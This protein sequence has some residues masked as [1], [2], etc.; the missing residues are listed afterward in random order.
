LEGADG[1]LGLFAAV[2]VDRKEFDLRQEAFVDPM[3]QPGLHGK[4]VVVV[5]GR[6]L[7]DSAFEFDVFPGFHSL[8]SLLLISR[9]KVVDWVRDFAF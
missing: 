3:I 6:V 1:Y 9:Q 8:S 4:D 2:A 5:V 7:T